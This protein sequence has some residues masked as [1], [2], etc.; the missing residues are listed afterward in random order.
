MDLGLEGRRALV[1]A[2]SSG[3]GKACAAAL[4]AE[5]TD[6]F[7]CARSPEALE[8]AGREIG[9]KGWL[10]ADVTVGADCG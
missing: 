4:A 1:T 10:V 9:A 7:I 2:A 3:I 6:V 5:G 8:A